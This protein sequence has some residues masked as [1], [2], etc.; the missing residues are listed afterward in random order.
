MR[1]GIIIDARLAVY[2]RPGNIEM[3]VISRVA[4]RRVECLSARITTI[5]VTWSVWSGLFHRA[6]AEHSSF[7]KPNLVSPSYRF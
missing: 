1:S 7:P 5:S 2:S 4:G 3:C 6:P